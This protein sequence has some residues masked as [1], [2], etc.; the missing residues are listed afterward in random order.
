MRTNCI[1]GKKGGSKQG[2]EHY[3]LLNMKSRIIFTEFFVN[4]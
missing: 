4:F 1:L 3:D 2:I